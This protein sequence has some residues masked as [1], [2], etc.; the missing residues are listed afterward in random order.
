MRFGVMTGI[1]GEEVGKCPPS[2]LHLA[3]K[4]AAKQWELFEMED[5]PVLATEIPLP[6]RLRLISYL[7]FYGPIME[8][9]VLDALTQGG[10]HIIHLDLAALAGHGNLSIS[11]LTKLAKQVPAASVAPVSSDEVLESWD[12]DDSFEAAL[13][14]PLSSSRFEQ[15]THLSLS[16]P[17][18]GVSWRDLLSFSKLIPNV[19]HLSL[20][21]WPRPTLT[22]NLVTATISSQHS[23]DVTA[24]GS[25]FYSVLD[26]D[27]YEP[28]SILRQLSS[29]LLRIT[30]LD[31]E[32]C[33]EWMPALAFHADA[34]ES[35]SDAESSHDG[36]TGVSSATSIFVRNWKNLLYVNCHQGSIPA[37]STL[38]S[39]PRQPMQPSHRAIIDRFMERVGISQLS[40]TDDMDYSGTVAQ[41]KAQMWLELEVRAYAAE[42]RINA[43]RR[44]SNIKL[45]EF[46]HGWG[47]SA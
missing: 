17:P 47:S 40:L 18:A 6:L 19:T 11:R 32:G 4:T 13:T 2:L 5:L 14:A 43:V 1:H 15:L 27:L 45:V 22:P 20:A 23:P 38:Q 3:L 21:Y 36:W 37:A 30:W 34:T 31:L 12:Q 44:S 7:A 9:N 25:H 35:R 29:H 39:L 41:R 42:R 16:H 8:P 10:E 28:A 26:E 24:G 46:D 33:T